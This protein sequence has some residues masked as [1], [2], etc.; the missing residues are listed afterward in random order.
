[1]Q[2]LLIVK[3]GS[4]FADLVSQSGDFEDWIL[5]RLRMPA[6]RV[7][8]IDVAGGDRLP[9]CDGMDGCVLTGSHAMVTDREPWSEQTAAWLPGLVA[10]GIPVL[11]ICYGHQ[12]LAHALGGRV[13]DNPRG[14]EFG[15]ASIELL[16]GAGLDP[17]LAGL[18]SPISGHTSHTQS[19]L[20]LPPRAE[21]L[22]SSDR[23]SHQAFRVGRCAWG[24]QFHPEFD[25]RVAAA[26][27]TRCREALRAEGQDPDQL[28]AA[29]RETP[30]AEEILRRFGEGVSS[31]GW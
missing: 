15:T 22:A 10:R 9:A 11:G 3:L 6:D 29:I 4:T 25:A 23:D 8:V 16:P 14:R 2:R 1:M 20:A 13:G 18:S 31:G 27:V 26:Y 17:L 28:E 5:Q 30:E 7:R 19:V 12:L 21:P 24:V